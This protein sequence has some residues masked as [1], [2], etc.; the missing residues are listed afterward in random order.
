MKVAVIGSRN[1]SVDIS[2]YIPDGVT[3]IISGG[4]RGIDS[5]AERYAEQRGLCMQI[6]KPDYTMHGKRAPLLRNCL[7]IDESDVVVAI[8]DGK[9]RGTRQ[10]IR[11]VKKMN[12]PLHLHI[13][14]GAPTPLEALSNEP[15]R[16]FNDIDS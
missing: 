10:A 13:I 11:Y 6:I 2:L 15:G 9:S 3:S 1:L 4:A 8:W 5:L 12:K 14:P 7:I 16:H